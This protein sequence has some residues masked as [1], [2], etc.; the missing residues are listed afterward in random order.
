MCPKIRI[1]SLVTNLVVGGDGNRLLAFSRALNRDRF[2]HTVLTLV[3]PDHNENRAFGLLKP[4]YDFYGIPV[5][6]LGEEPRSQRRRRQRGLSLLWG[7]AR[8]FTQVVRQLLRYVRRNE[9]DIIDARMTYATLFGLIVGR[10]AR[11]SAVVSTYYGPDDD[12]N[13]HRPVRYAV[14]QAMYS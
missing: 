14:A 6:H 5:E 9:I 3:A 1:L 2:Q 10:L 13:W 12:P 8:S 7:D 4:Q 11:V